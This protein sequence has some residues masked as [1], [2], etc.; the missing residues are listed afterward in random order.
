LNRVF[1]H[2]LRFDGMADACGCAGQEA[3]GMD[4][5]REVELV[6]EPTPEPKQGAEAVGQRIEE[7][8]QPAEPAA[9]APKLLSLSEIAERLGVSIEQL[10]ELA[11]RG[12]LPHELHIGRALVEVVQPPGIRPEHLVPGSVRYKARKAQRVALQHYMERLF[13]PII[14]Q[15]SI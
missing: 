13:E 6:Q 12:E 1:D 8:V 14:P 5:I 3:G 7:P 10:Q 9:P 2:F 11:R 15:R 4:E